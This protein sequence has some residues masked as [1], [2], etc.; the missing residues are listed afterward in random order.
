MRR[1]DPTSA[2]PPPQLNG[3]SSMR[4]L[5][6]KSNGARAV[7][8]CA[9]QRWRRCPASMTSVTCSLLNQQQLDSGPDPALACRP[10]WTLARSGDW[11]AQDQA[12]RPATSHWPLFFQH[13]R[14]APARFGR[15]LARLNPGAALRVRPRNLGEW[16]C[17]ICAAVPAEKLG[18]AVVAGGGRGGGSA[19]ADPMISPATCASSKGLGGPGPAPAAGFRPWRR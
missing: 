12:R 4:A 3:A 5:L 9:Q 6:R 16:A 19:A 14:N 18:L 11:Q 17:V 2:P 7:R 8:Q 10:C 13:N 1:P 15:C